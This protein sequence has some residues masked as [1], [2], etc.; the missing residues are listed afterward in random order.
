MR[1][2]LVLYLEIETLVF[3]SDHSCYSHLQLRLACAPWH[4]GFPAVEKQQDLEPGVV[5]LYGNRL[6]VWIF[7]VNLHTSCGKSY[8]NVKL[9]F[10]SPILLFGKIFYRKVFKVISC[11]SYILNIFTS[12]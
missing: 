4:L 12:F 1:K 3:S 10:E 7:S 6:C 11:T 5:Y 2:H 8:F 9:Q